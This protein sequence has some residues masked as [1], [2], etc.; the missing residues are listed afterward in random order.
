MARE[1]PEESEARR[2]FEFLGYVVT[3]VPE[4]RDSQ[5]ADYSIENGA[6]QFIAEVKSRGP[7]EHFEQ[8]ME[9]FGRAESQQT[10]GRS[11]PISKQISVAASQLAATTAGNQSL[12]R[13]VVLVAAG[14]DP[15][16]Q[17]EQ[18]QATLYGKVDLLREGRFGVVAVPC[19]YFT[20]NDFFRHPAIDA[21]V[22]L[23]PAGA[24][25]C[26]NSFARQRDQLG[27]SKLHKEL[28]AVGAVTDPE[29]QERLGD[30]F[31][32]D[33][34][35]DRRDEA[36]MLGYIRS[37]YGHPELLTFAPTKYRAAVKIPHKS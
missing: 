1:T 8:R 13:I 4:S 9:R 25:L 32:A 12:L 22:V 6:D 18:F 37:K 30:A 14:D 17:V 10:I 28:T 20:F 2:F 33:T 3:R 23:V 31:L 19:F 15:E 24:R 26:I 5:R 16:L 11:N 21:V 35:I 34:H 7:D 36:A 27:E 29:A